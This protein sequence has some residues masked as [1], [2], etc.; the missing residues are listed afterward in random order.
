MTLRHLLLGVALF[1]FGVVATGGA[2]QSDAP[3]WRGN[4]S[5]NLHLSFRPYAGAGHEDMPVEVL[6]FVVEV[7]WDGTGIWVHEWRLKNRSEKKVVKIRCALFVYNADD[8]TKLLLR[9]QL[10]PS[11]S[12]H[13]KSDGLDD[14]VPISVNELWPRQKCEGEWCPG[15]HVMESPYDL[16]HPNSIKPLSPTDLLEPLAKDGKIEGTYIIALGI[17]RVVFSDGTVWEFEA[18][19][20]N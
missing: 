17:D 16:L 5:G 2:T 11:Q 15:E 12:R 8:P 18:A 19:K 4:S 20:D 1:F 7:T 10:A 9:H 6:K 3:K 13:L 14:R